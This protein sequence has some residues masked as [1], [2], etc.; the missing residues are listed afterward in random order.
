MIVSAFEFEGLGWTQC[1]VMIPMQK[2]AATTNL[3]PSPCGLGSMKELVSTSL[4]RI[5]NNFYLI[6]IWKT[7]ILM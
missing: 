4:T 7:L 2:V 1:P 6:F 5:I 3:E